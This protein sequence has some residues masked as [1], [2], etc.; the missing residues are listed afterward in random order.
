MEWKSFEES[1]KE[2][3]QVVVQNIIEGFSNAAKGLANLTIEETPNK[4]RISLYGKLKTRFQ[5]K[6]ILLSKH[7]PD[8]SYKVLEFGYNTKL[9]PVHL[10]LRVDFVN[11]SAQPDDGHERLILCENEDAFRQELARV[12][13]TDNFKEVVSGLMKIA[14]KKIAESSS[15]DTV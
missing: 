10:L 12:F 11:E 1:K 14:T 13:N 7:L 4:D 8:Y 3:P 9:Y 5:F 6:L 15:E 2:L